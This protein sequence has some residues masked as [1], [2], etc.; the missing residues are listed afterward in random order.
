MPDGV[1]LNFSKQI[2]DCFAVIC[3]V[4]VHGP[5]RYGSECCPCQLDRATASPWISMQDRRPEPSEN[6]IRVW[7]NEQHWMAY[8][9]GYSDEW[10][11]EA[12]DIIEP[13]TWANVTHWMPDIA[14]PNG[15]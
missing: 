8:W 1:N 10:I 13:P 4:H 2:T 5:K 12:H 7:A 15:E 11:I 9:T 14:G 3:D 6:T